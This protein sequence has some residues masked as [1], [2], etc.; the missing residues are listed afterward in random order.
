VFAAPPILETKLFAE[1]PPDLRL[2]DRRSEWVAGQPNAGAVHSL[3]EGPGFT[4]DGR[5]YCVDVAH[6]RIFRVTADGRF[7]VAAEYDGEPNGLRI[8]KDGRIFIADYKN[9]LMLFDPASGSVSPIVQRHRVEHFR[10]INDLTF[11]ANGDL[12]FTDQ[13][14]T[15]LHDPGGRV[16]RLSADGRLG[17]LL[18]GIPSPNGLV[19]NQAQTELYLAV[20]R[21]NA[22]WRVPLLPDGGVA[23]VGRFIQL[24]GG[25]GPDG[26]AI[27]SA[28]NLLVAHVGLGCVWLFSPFGEPLLRIQ[29]CAGRGTTNITFGGPDNRTLYITEA[30]SGAILTAE[31]A[32]PGDPLY[33]HQ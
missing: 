29:S 9:G 24:S 3:L 32:T 22:I 2:P 10:A 25:Q 28:G 26:L 4:R 23:K 17:V 6:G 7:T 5:L 14:L 1:L 18:D 31:L 20:T 19:L 8:H 11:A 27:D 21:D 15:G 13:G 16:Y 12:Y 30:A 33:S